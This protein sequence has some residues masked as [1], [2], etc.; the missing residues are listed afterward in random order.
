MT[1]LNPTQIN[2]EQKKEI[3]RI[4]AMPRKDRRK[5]GKQLNVRIPGKNVPIVNSSKTLRT[6]VLQAY[7]K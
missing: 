7:G 4:E 5:L 6:G 3:D 2:E 1:L